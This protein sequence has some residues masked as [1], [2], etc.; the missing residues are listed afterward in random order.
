MKVVY[1]IPGS[2]GGF[3]C[4]NCLRDLSLV[5]ALRRLGADVVMAPMY[6]PLFEA[7][8]MLAEDS[9][10]F[11]GAINTYLEQ[12]FPP[13]RHTPRWL[14]RWFDARPL[15]RWVAKRAGAT[16]ARGLESMTLSMLEGAEG[17]QAKE[18]QR[19]LDWLAEEN[20]DV[21]HLSNALLLGLAQ[22]FDHFL[23]VS[24]V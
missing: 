23:Q 16:S 7:E 5:A 13:F 15:M 4:Q 18:L 21:V 24:F 8:G 17:N 1:V 12:V 19:L 20:P 6:L 3:Y 9:P 10:V 14:D 2:G 22:L 11:Y